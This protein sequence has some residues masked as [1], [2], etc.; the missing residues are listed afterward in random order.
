MTEKAIQMAAASS[1]AK[2]IPAQ[3]AV[4]VFEGI[5]RFE[6]IQKSRKQRAFGAFT[7]DTDSKR[8]CAENEC[9][10]TMPA[11]SSASASAGGSG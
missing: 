10:T 5:L 11:S 6:Q 2:S 1:R 3:T 4:R 9:E 7:E 8:V